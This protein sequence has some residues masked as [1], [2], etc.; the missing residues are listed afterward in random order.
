MEKL[1]EEIITRARAIAREKGRATVLIDGRCASGKSTL[2]AALAERL[3]ANLFHMDDFFLPF[4]KK[5]PE[6]LGRPGENVD[7]ERFLAEVLTPH[8]TGKPFSYRPFDCGRQTLAD[9]VRVEPTPITVVEG[10][11]SCRPG[12]W[13]YGDLH[14]FLTVAPEEQMRRI[15]A[16]NGEAMARRFR[17]EWIPLEEAYFKAFSLPERAELTDSLGKS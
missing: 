2:G 13:E 17:E 15:L 9:A 3:G 6:R 10:V 5:T 4:D 12:L 11:Y 1:I 7:H 16:R 8:A 14:V